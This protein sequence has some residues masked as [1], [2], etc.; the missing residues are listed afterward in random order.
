MSSSPL[1]QSQDIASVRCVGKC[2]QA[3]CCV[4]QR[5]ADFKIPHTSVEAPKLLISQYYEHG[6]SKHMEIYNY[7]DTDIEFSP[8]DENYKRAKGR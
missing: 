7:G 8:F 1:T 4:Q 5:T 6:L 3:D 2:S